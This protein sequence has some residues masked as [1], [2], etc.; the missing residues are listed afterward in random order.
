MFTVSKI[1]EMTENERNKVTLYFDNSIN[2]VSCKSNFQ[3]KN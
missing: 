3:K 2:G 1:M